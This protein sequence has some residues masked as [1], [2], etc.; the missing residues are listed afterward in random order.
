MGIGFI[1]ADDLWDSSKLE[2]QMEELAR[3]PG[4]DVC[5]TGRRLLIQNGETARFGEVVSVPP[6]SQ[7]RESLF[8][9]TIFLPS[10]VLI[11]KSTLMAVGGFD[12]RCGYVED[13]DL[14]LRLLHWGGNVVY[15]QEQRVRY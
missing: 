6:A 8:R 13:W 14:W 9:H 15:F 12:T 10:S 11:R 3:H 1:G 2:C 5:Y 4:A 7:I